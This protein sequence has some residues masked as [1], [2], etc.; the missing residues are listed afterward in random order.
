MD[1][2]Y[3]A[4]VNHAR[5]RSWNK[6]TISNESELSCSRKQR[7][8]LMG[9]N[10]R[11][12][13]IHRLRVRRTTHS[14][15]SPLYISKYIF[16][17]CCLFFSHYIISLHHFSFGIRHDIQHGDRINCAD[18]R[19]IMSTALLY[20]TRTTSET[21]STFSTC[22]ANDIQAYTSRLDWSTLYT[23]TRLWISYFFNKGYICVISFGI[24]INNNIRQ[25][26]H[27]K[28]TQLFPLVPQMTFKLILRG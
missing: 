2:A 9:L 3:F 21:Y 28:H 16:F 8:L 18:S 1:Q 7:E 10:S 20:P 19:Y 13:G 14:T 12:T 11:L 5:I 27:P 25:M 4:H 24:L 26:L 17:T 23:I 22:S 6:P 15:T